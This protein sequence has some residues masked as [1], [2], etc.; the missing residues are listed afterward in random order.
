M[1]EFDA[2][3]IPDFDKKREKSGAT[4]DMLDKAEAVANASPKKDLPQGY[5]GAAKDVG[6]GLVTG[7]ERGIVSLP[8][9]P[10]DLGQLYARAPA[11]GSYIYN[12]ISE[13]TNYAPV[14]TA[15]K[16]YEDKTR[17]IEKAMSPSE[18]AGL[19][20]NVFGMQLPTGHAVVKAASPYVPGLDYEPQ[21]GPGRIASSIGEFA[22][23]VP[24]FGA[25]G[26][27]VRGVSKGE[28]ALDIARKTTNARELSSMAGAGATSGTLGEVYRGTEDEGAARM[29][30]AIPGALV[31]RGAHARLSNAATVERGERLAGDVLR[32]A[33]PDVAANN[34]ALTVAPDSFVPGVKPS[35]PQL[36]RGNEQIAG[37]GEELGKMRESRGAE[38]NEVGAQQS[39]DKLKGATADLGDNVQRSLPGSSF[40][41]V[42]DLPVGANP[43]GVSSSQA[44]ALYEAVERPAYQAMEDAWKHPVFEQA[45]YKKSSVVNALDEAFKDMGGSKAVLPADLM[46][47]IEYI[48]NA[49]GPFISFQEVHNVKKYVNAM[50]RDEGLYDKRGPKALTSK[51]DDVLTNPKAVATTFMKGAVPGD[52]ATQFENA[53]TLTRQYHERFTDRLGDFAERV[54]GS[55]PRASEYVMQPEQMLDRVFQNPRVA[56][57]RYR[58][59]QNLPGLDISKPAGDWFIGHITNNGMKGAITQNDVMKIMRDPA[60]AQLIKEIPGLSNRL[61]NLAKQSVGEQLSQNLANVALHPNPQRIGD[62]IRANRADLNKYLS[63]WERQHVD[64]LERSANVLRDLDRGH[65]TERQVFDRLK[66]GDLF[67]IMHGNATGVI[68]RA[69]AGFAAGKAIG[70]AAPIAA[71]AEAIGAGASAAGFLPKATQALARVVYGTTQKEAIEALQR[72][73]REPEFYKYLQAKPTIENTMRLRDLLKSLPQTTGPGVV[74]GSRQPLQQ[75]PELETTEDAYRRIKGEEPRPLTI[76]RATGGAVTVDA[77][78]SAAE[79]AKN[80]IG[81]ETEPLLGTPDETIARALEIANKHI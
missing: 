67:T 68:G 70:I 22:G 48:R 57:E 43:K 36:M 40:S 11:I 52:M 33:A 60:N 17:E 55:S 7:A 61:E 56:L 16:A 59:L 1:S 47:Y 35:S 24:A 73:M 76:R 8:G 66:N 30:G 29:L 64:R 23:S 79:R 34:R 42:A 25:P 26:A 49:K 15:K 18:R 75:P 51:L 62:F 41:D 78:I 77:L 45:K 71:G 65:L 2:F 50:L 5:L 13:N 58:E 21:T 10:G 63:P 74:A 53:R 44:R 9:L 46:K 39:R 20:G 12:K 3:D 6:L 72:A 19:T 81:K 69:L 54:G 80:Q 32:E 27:I 14:G 37:L 28:R 4:F 31:G 38:I